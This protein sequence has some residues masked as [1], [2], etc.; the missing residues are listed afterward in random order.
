MDFNTQFENLLKEY[1]A[2][3]TIPNWFVSGIKTLLD[4]NITIE[5]W[6]RMYSYLE[7]MSSDNEVLIK[8]LTLVKQEIG[9]IYDKFQPQH[10]VSGEGV[11][12]IRQTS[13]EANGYYSVAIGYNTIANNKGSIAEG[14]STVADKN[15]AH[16]EGYATQALGDSSHTEGGNTKAIGRAAHAEGIYTIAWE[17]DS[18][19]EGSTTEA[20]YPHSHAEGYNTI[21]AS[22]SSHAEGEGVRKV[23]MITGNGDATEYTV[24]SNLEAIKIGY[25]IRLQNTNVSAIVTAIN[26]SIIT[27]SKTLSSSSLTNDMVDIFTG[28]IASQ[29][30]SE[31]S[32]TTASGIRSHAEGYNTFAIGTNAHAEGSTTEATKASSHAEGNA[33][34]AIA[35]FSHAE[36]NTTTASGIGAHAEGRN[37]TASG[38]YSHAE[39]GYT[40]A[41]NTYA[42]SGGLESQAQA[43]Q[44]FAHGRAV[45]AK[46]DNQFVVGQYNKDNANALFV[47]GNGESSSERNNALEVLKDGRVKNYSTPTEDTDLTSKKYVD[48]AISNIVNSAPEALNTLKE[49]ATALGNDPNF[50]TTILNKIS[51][52][53]NK[54]YVDS[55]VEG[56]I[57]LYENLNVQNGTGSNSIV[58]RNSVATGTNSVALGTE[59]QATSNSAMSEGNK[60][61]ASGW[62]SHAEGNSTK[63]TATG[64]HA[65]GRN[66]NATGDYSHAEGG[67]TYA[68]NTYAHAGGVDCRANG[69]NSFAHGK[70]LY[71]KENNQFVIGYNNK[72]NANALF[73]I[74]N[75][76]D[77]ASRTNALEVLDDG[78]VKSY[79][80][81]YENEDLATVTY[82]NSKLSDINSGKSLSSTNTILQINLKHAH[83]LV[84][85]GNFTTSFKL[86]CSPDTSETISF[87][88]M[89]NVLYT[90]GK[91]SCTH[92]FN[93]GTSQGYIWVENDSEKYIRMTTGIAEYDDITGDSTVFQIISSLFVHNEHVEIKEI[94]TSNFD[95]SI[96]D[97]SLATTKFI[98]KLF[99]SIE[100]NL[101]FKK[102]FEHDFNIPEDSLSN[103]SLNYINAVGENIYLNDSKTYLI[104][105]KTSDNITSFSNL[106]TLGETYNFIF[107]KNFP[108]KQ[109]ET[110]SFILS[111][112]SV[113]FYSDSVNDKLK[114]IEIYECGFGF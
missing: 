97:A 87:E 14:W 2:K 85:L 75:G 47:V 103:Y 1:D 49:L 45:C 83:P 32:G 7:R 77:G 6:N 21:A 41:T 70:N 111:R 16:A 66:T 58:Q 96:S 42:H 79:G 4:R 19:S 43:A 3:L 95:Y 73:I 55:A 53:P 68:T 91:V 81:P 22:T 30:H 114:K 28:A 20:L 11:E 37:N 9:Y 26:D 35:D 100:E 12:S 15:A 109:Y 78:R 18:H 54:E 108:E 99:E 10:F 8:L 38:N 86:N 80:T 40:K 61:T 112:E 29:S 105:L 63:A 98:K 24:T 88:H 62:Y 107:D 64:A 44:S 71:A 104:K 13:S 94:A 110:I 59:T 113:R 36:G 31:G 34:K 82:V 60:T 90:Y 5:D 17:Q 74:G 48:N 101:K 46:V 25:G 102:I 93:G 33:T 27:V 51:L 76:A 23:A 56:S 72:D 67:Y 89:C 106:C 84:E 52:L 69:V 92:T 65:E 50:A 39:G 57:V